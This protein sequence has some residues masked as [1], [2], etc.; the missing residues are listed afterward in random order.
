M[1]A[2]TPTDKKLRDLIAA[3]DADDSMLVDYETTYVTKGC[4]GT[5]EMVDAAATATRVAETIKT[6][7]DFQVA[8]KGLIKIGKPI[9][10][11][12]TAPDRS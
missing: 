1:T 3:G 7:K 5:S 10:A 8:L 4:L 11:V 6:G 2:G 9:R 12:K